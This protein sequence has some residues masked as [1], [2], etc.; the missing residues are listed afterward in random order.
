MLPGL[1]ATRI[2]FDYLPPD[3]VAR[4]EREPVVRTGTQHALPERRSTTVASPR[5]AVDA[6]FTTYAGQRLASTR[7]AASWL[8]SCAHVS[9]RR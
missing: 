3:N 1:W 6:G 5:T 4:T 7:S 2:S 9:P 8:A